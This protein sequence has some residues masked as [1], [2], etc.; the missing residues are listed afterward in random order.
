MFESV[1]AAALRSVGKSEEKKKD[2]LTRAPEGG[3]EKKKA[4]CGREE[5]RRTS[6]DSL[7]LTQ[8]K[9]VEL[10]NRGYDC[11]SAGISEWKGENVPS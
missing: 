7:L 4:E 10:R 11:G 3:K 9:E 2:Y 5:R 6:R 1:E 8:K